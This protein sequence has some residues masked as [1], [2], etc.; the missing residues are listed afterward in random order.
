MMSLQQVTRA[1]LSSNGSGGWEPTLVVKSKSLAL[2]YLLKARRIRLLFGRTKNENL[3]YGVFVDDDPECPLAIWSLVERNDELRA[4]R[5]I[6]SGERLMLAMFN[7]AVVNICSGL[8]SFRGP[9]EGFKG[10][11]TRV[12]LAARSESE[13]VEPEV[14]ARFESYRANGS[15]L[16]V[17]DNSEPV[18]WGPNKCVYVT[19]QLQTS[20]LDLVHSDEG[21]QQEQL[22]A[23]IT[24]SLH[25]G[26]VFQ[27]PT[28]SEAPPRELCDLLLTHEFGTMLFESKALTILSRPGLP[29]RKKL[30][31]DV[32]KHVRKGLRQLSGACKN[33]KGG[34]A[35]L[36]HNGKEIDM[37][38][39]APPHCIIIVPDLT[40]L[41]GS[42]RQILAEIAVLAEKATAFVNIVDL[43]QL[44]SLMMD[45]NNVSHRGTLTPLMAFDYLLIRRC[46]SMMQSR[47]PGVVTLCRF[48]RPTADR[49]A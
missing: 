37:Q 30:I 8:L 19:N 46:E 2:K 1:C 39:D 4:V 10:L 5:K 35:I 44:F 27:N 34:I 16:A 48:E 21:G 45:A 26:G 33:L 40:L 9:M 7:E 38:R 25:V 31:R 28:A 42:E 6:V 15:G 29:T 41:D 43:S 24:D 18:E 20:Q 14:S 49:H 11:L 23:W 12:R 32:V 47:D 36:S 13:T 22:A 17:L 3:F